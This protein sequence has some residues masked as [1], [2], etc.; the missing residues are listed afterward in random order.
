[1]VPLVWYTY[2]NGEV[3]H[4]RDVHPLVGFDVG[5]AQVAVQDHVAVHLQGIWACCLPAS[6]GTA[7]PKYKRPVAIHAPQLRLAVATAT[8]DPLNHHSTP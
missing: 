8:V 5:A 2:L 7:T 1:M 4:T 3:A 6:P